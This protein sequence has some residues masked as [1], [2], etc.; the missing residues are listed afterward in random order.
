[1]APRL[2]QRGSIWYATL[3]INGERKE[4]STGC[5][6]E[7]AARAVL[8]RWERDAANPDCAAA[9]ATLNDALNRLLTD[10]NARVRNGDCVED[11]VKFYRR[12]S[13]H[14]VRVLGH[15]F[16]L[17]RFE[18]RPTT[19]TRAGKREQVTQPSRKRQ[20]RSAQS[21]GSRRKPVCGKV[22]STLCSPTASI[23]NTNRK[24]AT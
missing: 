1:M 10:R 2:R 17:A 3:Y 9:E 5:T 23:R 6:D 20:T 4:C 8:A 11:A 7:E 15:D 13:G 12:Q 16:R 19:F 21:S 14:L 22:R 18:S 24:D